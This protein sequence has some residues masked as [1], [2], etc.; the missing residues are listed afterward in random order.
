[1]YLPLIPLELPV[2]KQKFGRRLT[3]KRRA[4]LAWWYS[5]VAAA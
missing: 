1:M 2:F 5:I 4:A 3:S